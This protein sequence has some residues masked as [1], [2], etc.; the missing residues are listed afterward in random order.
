MQER[1][2]VFFKSTD[3]DGLTLLWLKTT[4]PWLHEQDQ[5]YFMA[6][7]LKGNTKLGEWGSRAEPGRNN[8]PFHVCICDRSGNIQKENVALHPHTD[9]SGFVGLALI[10]NKIIY[11]H[12]QTKCDS[13]I[14]VCEAISCLSKCKCLWGSNSK[15][16][17]QSD[18]HPWEARSHTLGEYTN[19]TGFL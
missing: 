5:L 15:V 10:G 9:E 7:K 17:S 4:H 18:Y 1:K 14:I 8:P 11:L 12:K 16:N 13:W 3:P 2:S 19:L 6:W